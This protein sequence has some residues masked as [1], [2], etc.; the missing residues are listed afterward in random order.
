[1]I[2]PVKLAV[3]VQERVHDAQTAIVR[4]GIDL[5]AVLAQAL[6]EGEEANA[7]RDSPSKPLDTAQLSFTLADLLK[8]MSQSAIEEFVSEAPS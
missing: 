1:M 2:L 7:N 8:T 3:V 5:F 6:E 4:P